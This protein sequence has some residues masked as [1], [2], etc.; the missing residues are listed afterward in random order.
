MDQG[1]SPTRGAPPLGGTIFSFRAVFF[2]F[3][4]VFLRTLLSDEHFRGFPA[5]WRGRLTKVSS[6]T[7]VRQLGLLEALPVSVSLPHGGADP[8]CGPPPTLGPKRAARGAVQSGGAGE[9]VL[10]GD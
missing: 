3:H 9:A 5:T 6:W 10:R 4:P 8:V 2:P 1:W 7:H